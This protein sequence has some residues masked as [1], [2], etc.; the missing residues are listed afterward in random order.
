M[1]GRDYFEV[2]PIMRDTEVHAYYRRVMDDKT[3]LDFETKG[4]VV[5]RWE[6]FSVY[7][8]AEGGI[9]VYFRDI[10]EQKAAEKALRLAKLEADRANSAKS[11]FI[12]SA[13]HDLRQPV[14]SLAL[15]LTLLERQVEGVTKA[16][17][18]TRMMRSALGGLTALL[19]AI[20][21]ISRLDAGVIEPK[22]EAV[23]LGRLLEALVTEYQPKAAAQ[24]LELRLASRPALVQTD[25][26]LC[27]R[28]IRN[29][30]DNAVRYTRRGGVLVGVR[31]RGSSVRVD[32]VD[33]GAGVP[34][35]KYREIFEEFNQLDNPGRDLAKGLGLGLAIVARVA[36]LIGAKVEVSS[37]VGRRI[38]LFLDFAVGAGVERRRD[39][40]AEN[41]GR[42]DGR[43]SGGRGQLDCPPQP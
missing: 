43:H 18:T 28:A 34:K 16:V 38:A 3:P 8:T 36:T 21:D 24:G 39:S 5:K 4:P 6:Y 23:D 9:S 19:T 40:G 20:L 14:Q 31:G 13:S 17:S 27:E 25:A 7:P 10:A 12:A 30:I 26:A 11:R 29:L 32:V 35:E 15:L 1:L 22:L 2:F 37:R 41:A 33:T 42:R